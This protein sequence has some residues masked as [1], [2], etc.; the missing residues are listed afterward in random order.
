M[1]QNNE[2]FGQDET[3]APNHY[4]LKLSNGE[5][6]IGRSFYDQSQ[7]DSDGRIEMFEVMAVKTFRVQSQNGTV[8]EVSNLS[9]W[10]ELGY[11]SEY[12]SI[13]IES[14]V[15]ITIPKP[16]I[17]HSYGEN[18]IRY[19]MKELEIKDSGLQG[20]MKSGGATTSIEQLEKLITG[21]GRSENTEDPYSH[22]RPRQPELLDRDV[23][24]D[25]E[26]NNDIELPAEPA[27]DSSNETYQI[28][29]ITFH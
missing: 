18:V 14:I 1:H 8:L 20:K 19:Y 4:F 26:M 21:E 28:N 2:F 15:G 16:E 7:I 12:V 11:F 27:K 29:G 17:I 24:F 5:S 23:M 25:A 13:P 9:P 22:A 6:I 3:K 10:M